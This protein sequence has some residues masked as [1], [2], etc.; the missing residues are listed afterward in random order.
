MPHKQAPTVGTQGQPTEKLEISLVI[1]EFPT[2]NQP[3]IDTVLK[4]MLMSL[5]SS[6]HADMMSC[7]HNYNR[8]DNIEKK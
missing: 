8:L 5:R 1:E 3:V 6:L 4:D 7:M 2:N